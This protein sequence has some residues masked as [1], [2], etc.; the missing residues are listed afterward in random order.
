MNVLKK[1][2]SLWNSLPKR[3]RDILKKQDP[4]VR[5][6]NAIQKQVDDKANDAGFG[7]ISIDVDSQSV[8]LK[9]KGEVPAP[10]RAMIARSSVKVETS[11]SR[12]SL[13]ESR[14]YKTKISK[15]TGVSTVTKKAGSS[16][17]DVRVKDSTP[18]PEKQRIRNATPMA[19][20]L[21]EAPS[22]HPAD[23]DQTSWNDC[24]PFRGGDHISIPVGIAVSGCTTSWAVRES[25][26]DIDMLTAGHCGFDSNGQ[27]NASSSITTGGDDGEIGPTTYGDFATYQ[28]GSGG[29][30]GGMDA[31]TITRSDHDFIPSFYDGAWNEYFTW[32]AAGGV[33]SPIEGQIV[34][35]TGAYEGTDC[36]S[37]ITDADCVWS[38]GQPFTSMHGFCTEQQDGTPTVGHGDSGGPVYRIAGGVSSTYALGTI[39][40]IQGE[41]DCPSTSHPANRGALC[42][43]IAFHIPLT[44]TLSQMNLTYVP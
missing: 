42:S 10:L 29:G 16:Q 30:T 15:M 41:E 14:R 28:A 35:T 39:T 17:L 32:E 34:C 13:Q 31:A 11:S 22:A 3:I 19:V 23:C 20:S 43:T 18:N 26:G 33:Q 25:N 4:L 37:K 6:A 7:G 2:H 1:S 36:N 21:N 12:Y 40:A 38:Y 8:H 24:P 9:W 5:E 44:R 27:W